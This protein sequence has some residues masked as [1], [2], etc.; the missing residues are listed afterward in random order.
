MVIIVENYDPLNKS[1]SG[2]VTVEMPVKWIV[3]QCKRARIRHRYVAKD[4]CPGTVL[5]ND[6]PHVVERHI[7]VQVCVGTV[8]RP[9]ENGGSLEVSDRSVHKL[10]LETVT[11][12]AYARSGDKSAAVDNKITQEVDVA[13]KSRRTRNRVGTNRPCDRC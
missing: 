7:T 1:A 12:D 9:C 2:R 8:T 3:A 5:E 13:D 11:F 6:P 10:N 4:R